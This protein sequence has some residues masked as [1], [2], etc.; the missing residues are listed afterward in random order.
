MEVI[1]TFRKLYQVTL[2]VT[3]SS[4]F[5][6]AFPF[7]SSIFHSKNHPKWGSTKKNRNIKLNRLY[8]EE[9]ADPAIEQ[10]LAPL[11]AQVK[12]QVSSSTKNYKACNL[13]RYTYQKSTS[14]HHYNIHI[15]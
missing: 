11:R 10:V 12:E 9:M 5:V 13:I 8:L 15:H 7:H 3:K 14:I 6:C 4:Q 2:N 1:N